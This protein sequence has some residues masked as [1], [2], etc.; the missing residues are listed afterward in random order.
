MTF[1]IEV[2]VQ[3]LTLTGAIGLF[4]Y[5]M[6]VM[7]ESLQ[8]IAGKGI[9][10]RLTRNISTPFKGILAG[11]LITGII[12][13]SSATTVMLVSFVNAGLIPFTASLGLIFGA[14]I[15]TTITAWLI[16]IAG[17]NSGFDFYIIMLPMI[18]LSI[19]FLLSGKSGNRIRAEFI[20]GFAILFIGIYLF[21]QH[22]PQIDE[23]SGIFEAIHKLSSYRLVN[24]LLFI[25]SGI[26][27]TVLFQSSSATIALTMVLASQGWLTLNDALAMVLGIN[28]GTTIT[29]NIAA[30]VAN[31]VAKRTALAHLFFNLTGV[32]WAVLFFGLITSA[33]EGAIQT[34]QATT[35]K[36]P[37]TI[38]PIGIAIF[39]SSFNIINTIIFTIFFKQF[40]SLC[41]YLL[42]NGEREDF[43]LKY[44]DSG[45]I[46]MSQLSIVQV[47]MEVAHLSSI[48]LNLYKMIPDL[49]DEKNERKFGKKIRNIQKLEDGVDNLELCIAN[50]ITHTFQSNLS[51][52]ESQRLRALL[53]M[54]DNLESIADMSYQMSLTISRKNQAAAWF[55]P[56]LRR[57][58]NELFGLVEESLKT[59]NENL[60][61][62]FGKI[63]FEKVK[64]IEL[65]INDLRSDLK[66]RY[67]EGLK[68]NEYPYQT[69]VLYNDMLGL[70]EKIGDHVFNVNYAMYS[71]K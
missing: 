55:T 15:G 44:I 45:M 30:L 12:Q 66:K 48:V 39:H 54:I 38:I 13:S 26:I 56:E 53:K 60:A 64:S 34:L 42:P 3:I 40:N 24:T 2:V 35:G 7:S 22:I 65:E 52:K 41:I 17:I 20:I 32:L 46:S 59:M 14:N 69:G 1:I 49:L 61:G 25:A 19:P 36:N 4:L 47:K 5:G 23:T 50:Y 6:K 67:M 31:R 37:E 43:S 18:G 8:K 21:K 29:A 11:V 51:E 27:L 71:S 63:N 68:N 33:I 16:S 70:L 57:N 28:I 10:D 62:D 58:L 9:R